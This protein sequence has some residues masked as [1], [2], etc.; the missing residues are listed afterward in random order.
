MIR[1]VKLGGEWYGVKVPE[2]GDDEVENI[3]IFVN[4]GNFIIIGEDAESIEDEFN[5]QIEMVK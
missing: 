4:E 5:I 1:A 2:I 3:N